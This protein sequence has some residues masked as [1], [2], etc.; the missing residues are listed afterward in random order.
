MERFEVKIKANNLSKRIL[1]L[2]CIA[3]IVV[4]MLITPPVMSIAHAEHDH[5]MVLVCRSTG[6]P[7]CK[8]D[9]IDQSLFGN[10]VYNSFNSF[11]DPGHYIELSDDCYICF[12]I[13]KTIIKQRLS[14]ITASSTI[15]LDIGT[16]GRD[17][18]GIEHIKSVSLTPVELMTTQLN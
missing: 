4:V 1:S 12:F 18:S 13:H 2:S 14:C 16:C 17:H 10:I 6:R 11:S 7:E 9:D 3:C 8:C 15:P 5:D